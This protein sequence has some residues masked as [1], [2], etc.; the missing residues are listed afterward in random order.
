MLLCSKK[1][2]IMLPTTSHYAQKLSYYA[3]LLCS[4]K[5][6]IMLPTTSHYAL[7]ESHYATLCLAD[8]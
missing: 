4:K 6:T 1:H 3:M 5:H 2:T 8:P 7:I